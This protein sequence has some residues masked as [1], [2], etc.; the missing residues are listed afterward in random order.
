MATRTAAKPAAKKPTPKKPVV[1]PDLTAV[2]DGVSVT[3]G[4]AH[5]DLKIVGSFDLDGLIAVAKRVNRARAE[6]S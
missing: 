3:V 1:A 4:D 5:A 6:L 2:D